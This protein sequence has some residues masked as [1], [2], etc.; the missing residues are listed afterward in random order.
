MIIL[1]DATPDPIHFYQFWLIIGLIASIGANI[2]IIIAFLIN[3]KEKREVSLAFE[4][5]SEAEFQKHVQHNTDRHS[6]LFRGIEAAEKK[7]ARELNE[8]ALRLE[9]R[10][11]ENQNRINETLRVMPTE[12]VNMLKSTKGLLE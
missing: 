7:A 2:V 1:A 4:P 12:I 6:Q 3:R 8:R 9:E 11:E 5:A 10:M